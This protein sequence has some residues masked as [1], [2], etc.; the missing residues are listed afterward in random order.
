[1]LSNTKPTPRRRAGLFA[2]LQS[3]AVHGI[4]IALLAIGVGG[5]LYKSLRPGG[6]L[7]SL[8]SG[9]VVD[10]SWTVLFGI[11]ALIGVGL[12]VRQWLDAPEGT[13]TRGDLVLYAAM[14]LGVFFTFELIVNGSL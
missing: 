6:W 5:F 1:M 9:L 14:G 7:S 13:G 10:G 11:G 12:V 3:V 8:T 4:V 2:D